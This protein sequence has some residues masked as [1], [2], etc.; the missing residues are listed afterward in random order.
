MSWKNIGAASLMAMVGVLGSSVHAQDTRTQQAVIEKDIA[1]LNQQI[2]SKQQ[3]ATALR[4]RPSV[5]QA[6]LAAAQKALNDARADLKSN[7]TPETEGKARNA[8]FK[9]KLAQI[10]YDKAHGD[11]EA[12]NDEIE[13][14]KQQ[15]ASK[16]QQI[17]DLGKASADPQIDQQQQKLADERNK[18]QQQDQELARSKQEAEAAR[19]EIERLKAALASKEA[20]EAKAQAAAPV[21]APTPAA[22]PPAPVVAGKSDPAK[23]GAA[24]AA[25]DSG[26]LMKLDSQQAVLHA[27]QDFAQ[28]TAGADARRTINQ[29][30]YVKSP[31][32]AATNKDKIT[33]RGLGNDQYRGSSNIAAGQYETVLGFSRWP[34]AFSASEAGEVVFLLD[35]SNAKEPRLTIYNSALEGGK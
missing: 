7:P 9:F 21:T 14:L 13:R 5:E 24:T 15:V 27:L 23:S 2:S 11:V 34:V 28:R 12:L 19:K 10:K 31:N 25:T 1:A 35:Y 4:N 22:A 16:Q 6:E 8:E 3:Q 30:L 29:S 18:R 32:T 26:N 33:L 17:K 20:A